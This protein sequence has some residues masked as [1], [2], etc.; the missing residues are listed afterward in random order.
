LDS[1]MSDFD[2]FVRYKMETYEEEKVNELALE[3]FEE[4]RH[5]FV[6]LWSLIPLTRA[7]D[8][9]VISIR[10]EK[11]KIYSLL[12]ELYEENPDFIQ[13]IE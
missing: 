5:R 7:I 10:D 13:W 4:K 1:N 2:Q 6:Y 3:S 11:T 12:R 9:L 8:T